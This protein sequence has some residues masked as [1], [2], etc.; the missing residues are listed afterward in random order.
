MQRTVHVMISGIVQGVGYRA[1]VERQAISLGLCGWV[2]NRKDGSV[3]A[4]FSGEAASVNAILTA[5][6]R[7]PRLA[8]VE[9]VRVTERSV[10]GELREFDVLPTD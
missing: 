10:D 5:C 4:I 6:Q 8:M 9:E 7:G 3:E 1:F 2:R